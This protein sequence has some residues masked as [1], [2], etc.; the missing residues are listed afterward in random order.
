MQDVTFGKAHTRYFK[1]DITNP[2]FKL[3][4]HY[5]AF[6]ISFQFYKRSHALHAP[7]QAGK[8]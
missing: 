3:L 6:H 8:G 4:V 1:C 7:K 2:R 5:F